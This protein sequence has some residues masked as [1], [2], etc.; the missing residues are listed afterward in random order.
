MDIKLPRLS[1]YK[2]K[3]VVLVNENSQSQA[4]YTAM[5]FHSIKNSTIAGNT[6]ADADGN[7]SS[8][9]FIWWT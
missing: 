5:A 2:G 6:T 4:E 7:V 1:N 3:L 9:F 8:I